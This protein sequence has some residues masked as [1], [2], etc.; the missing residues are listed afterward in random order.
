MNRVLPE[1]LLDVVEIRETATVAHRDEVA[2]S[3]LETECHTF[4]RYLVQQAPT[5]YVLRKYCE[6]HEKE[7]LFR[8]HKISAF[9][10]WLLRL[11]RKGV[12]GTK[13]ADTYAALFA[14]SALMRRKIILLLAI[15]E[16][17]AP[18]ATYFEAPESTQRVILLLKLCWRGIV[19]CL[20]LGCAVILLLPL[21]L[22]LADAN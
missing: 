4:A 6:A 5:A 13:L 14:R 11:A 1:Q 18:S 2:Q 22:C 10:R 20:M 9:E 7:L 12:L 21:Q 17:C 15:L 19:F 8:T 3:I 16:S